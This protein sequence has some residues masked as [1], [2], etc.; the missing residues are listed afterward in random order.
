M[1][2][3]KLKHKIGRKAEFTQELEQRFK[4]IYIPHYYRTRDREHIY[5]LIQPLIQGFYP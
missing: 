5:F 1:Q 4:T 3:V 2:D